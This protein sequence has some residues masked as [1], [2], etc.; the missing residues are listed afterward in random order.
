M[1][2]I[3][4]CSHCGSSLAPEVAGRVCPSCQAEGDGRSRTRVISSPVSDSAQ[5]GLTPGQRLGDYQIIRLLGQG[6]MGAVYEAEQLETGR[7]LALKV[8]HHAPESGPAR[9]RFLREGRLAASISHPNSVYI[10]GTEEINGIPAITMEYV[11]GGTLSDRV[12]RDGPIPIREAVDAILQVI[13]GLE[14]A[15]AKGVL[16]RD[17]KP[18]NCFVETDGTVKVGDFG[19]SVSTSAVQQTNLTASGAIMGTPAYASPEQLRG[20]DIDVRSDIYSVGVTL[21]YL[22]T[23]KIPFD[24]DN[25][26]TLLAAVLE[27][28]P[29]P[30][31]RWRAEI[32]KELSATIVR[33]LA[34][35]PAQRPKSYAHLR[36]AL[37]PFT[38]TATTPATL[39]WRV[40]A[41]L[42]DYGLLSLMTEIAWMVF[43]AGGRVLRESR[44]ASL[45]PAAVYLLY[46][47]IPEGR[48]G[49][50][51][52]KWI[53]QLRVVGLDRDL[54]GFR[55]AFARAVVFSAVANL[56]RWLP[57][58][59][60]LFHGDP[61]G[62]GEG[63]L[64]GIFAI[65]P[66]ALMFIGARRRN[67]F[68]GLHDWL[69]RSRVVER[70]AVEHRPALVA[71][72]AVLPS[73]EAGPMIG[74]FQLLGPLAGAEGMLLGFDPRLHRQVWI[75]TSPA[76]APPYPAELR[77]LS[78]QGRLRWL[79]GRRSS[80]ESWDAF[81]AVEGHPL[82]SLLPSRP[83]WAA[84]RFWLSDLAEELQAAAQDATWPAAL[85]LDRVWIS[86][87]GRAKLLDFPAPG[88][89]P[90]PAAS[91]TPTNLAVQTTSGEV[92]PER[93][94][95]AQAFLA[96]VAQASLGDQT[97]PPTKSATG[98]R[99]PMPMYAREF[100]RRLAS[101]GGPEAT[102]DELR[103]LLARPAALSRSRRAMVVVGCA[104][105]VVILLFSAWL[106]L[107]T[108]NRMFAQVPELFPLLSSVNYLKDHDPAKTKEGAAM[109]IYIAS[110]FRSLS[111]NTA[112][113]SSILTEN[114]FTEEH[115]KV[116]DR[117]LAAHPAPKPAEIREA[118][119]RLKPFLDTVVPLAANGIPAKY[120]PTIYSTVL[121][122]G[123]SALLIAPSLVLTTLLRRG[124]LLRLLRIEIVDRNGAPAPRWRTLL[125]ATVAWLPLL[126]ALF[127]AAK[128]SNLWLVGAALTPMLAGT[129]FA[130]WAPDRGWQD[131]LAG[132]WLTPA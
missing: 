52:G 37:L 93:S 100:L 87:D 74:S 110:H 62:P 97:V 104:V 96:R 132:T 36:R 72:A 91:N 60:Q 5:T 125:R 10:F 17:V 109:E 115:R 44:F 43:I 68:A 51:V 16:H 79:A 25:V 2:T 46:F 129:I 84:V 99:R 41:G 121:T 80:E 69:T 22:L 34:K 11:A 56:P 92:E 19:L 21:Y 65:L 54:P 35:Q 7:R 75:R 1:K 50:S 95:L 59:W 86:A 90:P 98:P 108:A 119:E 4:L 61:K 53:C 38:S 24:S 78:R 83:A 14:A 123:V 47:A 82:L 117:V 27:K 13:A 122:V 107:L 77:H 42:I 45:A 23:G 103:P 111:T 20:A 101:F 49:A 9:Q 57:K 131:R 66:L 8:L 73:A 85:A 124:P 105:P 70:G 127:L 67:G 89:A 18:S 28:A 15:A 76:G 118:S 39:G 71:P 81:E 126:V 3:R 55:R 128:Q 32:P 64:T 112:F 40:F 106:G 12:K 63:L 26:I 58:A 130:I 94:I 114:I 102:L 48:W 30:P 33:C 88:S 120:L 29:E 116:F 31:R 6:G 113:W